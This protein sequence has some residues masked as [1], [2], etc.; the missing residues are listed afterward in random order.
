MVN[1]HGQVLLLE[2]WANPLLEKFWRSWL[3][4]CYDAIAKL[5]SL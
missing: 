5:Y 1:F 2:M 4:L 3:Y